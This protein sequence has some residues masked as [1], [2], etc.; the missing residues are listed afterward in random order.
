MLIMAV[1]IDIVILQGNIRVLIQYERLFNH[2]I[3]KFL[4]TLYFTVSENKI[5]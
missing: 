4:I 5:V 3:M 2:I 1:E